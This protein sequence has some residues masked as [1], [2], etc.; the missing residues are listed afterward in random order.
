MDAGCLISGVC[1][2]PEFY[3]DQQQQKNINERKKKPYYLRIKK[4]MEKS[5]K[6]VCM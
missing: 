1:P 4:K 5:I 2:F 3:D 6:I